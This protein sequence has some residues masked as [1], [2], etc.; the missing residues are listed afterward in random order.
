[1]WCPSVGIEDATDA[2]QAEALVVADLELDGPLAVVVLEAA[3]GVDADVDEERAAVQRHGT[4]VEDVLAGAARPEC[5]AVL[6]DVAVRA[7]EQLAVAVGHV[8]GEHDVVGWA[9]AAR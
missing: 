3:E 5:A 2:A 4:E 7:E 8:D 6:D 9:P 1:M